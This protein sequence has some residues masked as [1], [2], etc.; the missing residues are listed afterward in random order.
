MNESKKLDEVIDKAGK[1]LQAIREA[2]ENGKLYG[3]EKSDWIGSRLAWI[4]DITEDAETLNKRLVAKRPGLDRRIQ[5][6]S[7]DLEQ[8]QLELHR[9]ILNI[10]STL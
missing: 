10:K 2:K 7:D 9:H 1:T 4:T 5:A 6:L 8:I 3:K